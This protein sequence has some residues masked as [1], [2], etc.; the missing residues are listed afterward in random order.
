[1]PPPSPQSEAEPLPLP[2]F[3][4]GPRAPARVA[5]SNPFA[6]PMEFSY[7]SRNEHRSSA[8]LGRSRGLDLSAGPIVQDGQL[9]DS[10]S[11][12]ASSGDLE[13]YMSLVDE[14]VDAHKY[15][16]EEARERQEEGGST[17]EVTVLRD[18]TVASVK[19]LDSSDSASLDEAW[20]AVFRGNHLPPLPD[21]FPPRYVFRFRLNYHLIYGPP[22]G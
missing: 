10:V 5:P 20:I 1:M 18:G 15:Y 11:H 22:R 19:L 17:V 3:H 9:R 2:S 12:V 7:A 14:F 6:H 4:Y 16:P 8:G 21:G 13:D